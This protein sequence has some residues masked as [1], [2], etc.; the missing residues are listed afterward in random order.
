M[1]AAAKHCLV[2]GGRWLGL[3]WH[4]SRHALNLVEMSAI[5]GYHPFRGIALKVVE[6]VTLIPKDD[7]TSMQRICAAR[8]SSHSQFFGIVYRI[9][10]H[11]SNIP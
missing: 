3:L 2:F 9:V 4:H 6:D 5:V 1:T 7:C 8:S 10:F 11:N